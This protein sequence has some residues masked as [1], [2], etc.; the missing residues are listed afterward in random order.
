MAAVMHHGIIKSVVSG[1]TIVLMGADASKGP[2]PEKLLS[3]TGIAAP[4][5]GNKSSADEPFAWAARE[6]L[7]KEGVGKRV[8]FQVEAQ[9]AA[10]NR[11]FGMVYMEDGQSL[12]SLLVTAGWAKPRRGGEDGLVEAG[13]AAEA[14][15]LGMYNGAAAATAVRDVKWA[16]TFDAAEVL[17]RLKGTPQEAIIEQVPTGSMMRVMLLPGYY[18]VT[19]ML[20]GIQCAGF[21]R[22]DDGSEEAQPFA[23]EARYFV[24]TRLL[25]RDVHVN[26]EGVD[27][28]GSLLGTVIHP[29]GNISVELVKVG[30]ARVV[31][32][33]SQLTTAAPLLRA[34]ER[35]AKN[36]RL[37]MWKDYIAPVMG[38]DMAEFQGKVCEI[39]SGDTLLVTDPAGQ[40]RRFSLS[41]LR[42]PRMG[43][44]PEPY[45]SESKESLRKMLIGRK[46]KVVP[47]YK[48][49]FGG[50][51]GQGPAEARSFAT[52]IYNNERNAGMVQI[53]EGLAVVMKHGGADERSAH[54]EAM[55]EAEEAARSGK[56]GMHSTSDYSNTAA[57]DLTKPEA[58]D[59]AKRFLTALQR[60]GKTRGV[61]QFIPNATRFKL[62]IPK[63][64]AV[65]SF[66][67]VGMR[68]PQCGR[69]DTGQP[70]EPYGD[71]AL[72]FARSLTFQRDVDIEVETVDKNGNFLGSLYLPDKRSYGP[73]LLE[74]GLARLVQPMADRSTNAL[75]LNEAE[76]KA[77]KSG[78]KVWEN[79]SAEEEEAARQAA[80]ALAESELEPVADEEKQV[81]EL[82]LTEIVNGAHFYAQVAGDQAVVALQD[83]LKKSCS[84][85]GT[86]PFE[87]KAGTYCCAR[88]TVD[89]EWYRAKVV[90]KAGGEFTV[91]F[92]DY[93]NTDV[94]K[95]DRLKP[96][97]PSLG[98]KEI[99]PQA[100]ECKLAYL[101][102]NDPTDGGD[103]E[104]AAYALSAH[105][106]KVVKARVEVRDGDTLLVTLTG[107]TAASS[108]V[109]EELVEQGLLRVSKEYY[110]KRMASLVSKMKEREE[111]ARK[112]RAGMWKY[113]DIDEDEDFEFGMR[114]QQMEQAKAANGD[115]KPNAWGKK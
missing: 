10:G 49:T 59:R 113:G 43:R 15:G 93:G 105:M 60:Q 12:A 58:R 98:N 16:G 81:V 92:I 19:L 26:L 28:N 69:R 4:R 21:R 108:S 45:A 29:A 79:Y 31:D 101:K 103:G 55:L 13:A 20:S 71:E 109:N 8:T 53:Q 85:N 30:L 61:V 24:E 34:A 100:L 115:A 63:E 67:L 52:I 41:S 6:F 37:R 114:K 27:K 78:L 106:G 66:A 62:L 23:R 75:E 73:L 18:Q 46:V 39:I 3:L 40:E 9:Q 17:S 48:R 84:T 99:S 88:F 72:A 80:K 82:E 83:Q 7:R 57:T 95:S 25:N 68:C 110:P 47:E 33:S 70:G 2:P 36:K 38:G 74:A 32:W 77:K 56:K 35:D 86:G 91:F 112:A 89:N 94:V 54:F 65:V 76:T 1:D 5:M 14:A 64:N 104:D 44:D 102:A 107:G 97:D 50:G 87:P 11:A 42:C 90:N 96:L 22:N 51:E 111:S